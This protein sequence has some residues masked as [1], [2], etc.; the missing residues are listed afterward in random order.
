[1]SSG[2][3]PKLFGNFYIKNL[4]AVLIAGV[5]LVVGV[6]YWLNSYTRHNEALLVPDVK[7]LSVE[8]AAPFLVG[9]SLR[10]EV[11]DSIYARDMAPG[12]IIE[13]IPAADSKV[14]ANR[15]I[16]LVV[17]ASHVQM[18][19]LPDVIDNSLRQAEATLNAL[20]FK[21]AE[22]Q[23]VQSE[24]KDLVLEVC[25]GSRVVTSG[26]KLPLGSQVVLRVGGEVD[27]DSLQLDEKT[28]VEVPKNE[29]SW[30]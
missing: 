1:M 28:V 4:I 22:I 27:L 26:T 2:F 3:L 9:K 10:F 24:W 5:A 6:L 16:F 21:I 15:I 14:K 20:G 25:V 17:N 11:I 12:A 23:I 13:Q 8:A 30:F 19:E 7:G 18:V 29:E